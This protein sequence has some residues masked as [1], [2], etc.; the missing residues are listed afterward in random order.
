[1]RAGGAVVPADPAA[2]AYLIEMIGEHKVTVEKAV[3]VMGKIIAQ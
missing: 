3:D 2:G 1:M